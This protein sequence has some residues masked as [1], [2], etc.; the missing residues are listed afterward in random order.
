MTLC[1]I[2]TSGMTHISILIKGGQNGR[3][4]CFNCYQR[5]NDSYSSY[6]T[7]MNITTTEKYLV[8]Q[9]KENSICTVFVK[10]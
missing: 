4:D 2:L 5:D 9:S 3:M 8:V 6:F 7:T 1:L 10:D